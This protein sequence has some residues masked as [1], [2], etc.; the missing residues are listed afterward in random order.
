MEAEIAFLHTVTYTREIV[1]YKRMIALAF[2]YLLTASHQQTF[3]LQWTYRAVTT[4]YSLTFF[5]H[6]CHFFSPLLL[7]SLHNNLPGCQL[8]WIAFELI[9]L[10]LWITT[11]SS[12]YFS[13]WK[14]EETVHSF[15]FAHCA[16]TVQRQW[17]DNAADEVI[18]SFSRLARR[19]LAARTANRGDVSE[20]SAYKLTRLLAVNFTFWMEILNNW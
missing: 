1:R 3:A 13:C 14:C 12:D 11:L 6:L 7:P 10:L 9:L 18:L 2:V 15:C 16:T 4:T 8:G 5:L 20:C 17:A 19:L